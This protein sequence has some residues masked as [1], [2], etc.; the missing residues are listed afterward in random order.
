MLNN[1]ITYNQYYNGNQILTNAQQRLGCYY[2][3]LNRLDM[4]GKRMNISLNKYP[5]SN[6]E[7]P[8]FKQE[9]QK[10]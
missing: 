1:N 10:L 7:Y 5:I 9:I 3:I 6:K 2:E 4:Q 8:M